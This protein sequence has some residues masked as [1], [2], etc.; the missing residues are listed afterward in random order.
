MTVRDH[1]FCDLAL[2]VHAACAKLDDLLDRYAPELDASDS[3][4]LDLDD[5][6]AAVLG[7]IAFRRRLGT[8]FAA[9]PPVLDAADDTGPSPGA[10][11]ESWLR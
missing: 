2:G 9:T 1:V 5:D 10:A 11:H 3:G 6:I 4:E 7:L 8:A